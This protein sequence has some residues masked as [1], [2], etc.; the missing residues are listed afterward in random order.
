MATPR[1]DKDYWL[2]LSAEARGG[3]EDT[4]DVS[5]S[6]KDVEAEDGETGLEDGES[7][8]MSWLPLLSR[9]VRGS[10]VTRLMVPISC[11]APVSSLEVSHSFMRSGGALCRLRDRF[12]DPGANALDRMES[13]LCWFLSTLERVEGRD[14]VGKRP[15]M[16]IIGERNVEFFDTRAGG[17]AYAVSEQ[18]SYDPRA[19][20][21]FVEAPDMGIQYSSVSRP[22]V[23]LGG[24]SV[25]MGFHGTSHLSVSFGQG[26]RERYLIESKPHLVI[27]NV[28]LG[29]CFAEHAGSLVLR[30]RETGLV[31]HADF[32]P[33]GFMGVAGAPPHQVSGGIFKEATMDCVKRLGGNWTDKVYC[34]SAVLEAVRGQQRKRV[35]EED[36]AVLFDYEECHRECE[37]DKIPCSDRVRVRLDVDGLL[38]RNVWSKVNQCLKDGDLEAAAQLKTKLTH[39]QKKY[40]RMRRATLEP[41]SPAFFRRSKERFPCTVSIDSID[42]GDPEYSIEQ[43]ADGSG[44]IG[45]WSPALEAIRC[46]VQPFPQL[47]RQPKQ[48][49]REDL[50]IELEAPSPVLYSPLPVEHGG[51]TWTISLH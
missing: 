49:P 43:V 25:R 12:G 41:H 17:I 42:K 24:N 8:H 34:W 32:R 48:E 36:L 22:L 21:C 29:R 10:D 6:F 51:D 20:A 37:I 47:A 5:E 40:H 38:S 9:I 28:S 23:T 1:T 35:S 30:C 13:V 3:E 4:I 26:R 44:D 33:A 46:F 14:A 18:L 45:F 19:V 39:T 27:R 50:D 7:N 11:S 15:H 31:A 2:I 16:P